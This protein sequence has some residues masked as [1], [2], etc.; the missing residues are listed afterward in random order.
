ML[1]VGPSD[2]GAAPLLAEQ[3]APWLCK[4]P[5]VPVT[6]TEVHGQPWRVLTLAS[7]RADL[8][9]IG[10]HRGDGTPMPGL[11][12]VSYAMLHHA[13]CPVALVPDC[14]TGSTPRLGSSTADVDDAIALLT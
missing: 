1:S 11:G 9:V 8:V 10:G 14:Q 6:K 3:I 7:G 2:E 13:C 5:G 4:Y 12:S